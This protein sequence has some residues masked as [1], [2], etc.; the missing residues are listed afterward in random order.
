MDNRT[1]TDKKDRLLVVWTSSDR[2]VALRMLFMYTRNAKRMGWWDDVRLL[3]WGPSA[4]LLS[5]DEE[6]KAYIRDMKD[7][8]IE[9]IACKACSDGYGVSD[10]LSDLGVEVMYVGELFTEMLQDGW[11]TI[12][13]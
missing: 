2:E 10:A 8:G 9:L 6:L 11:T 1:D 13:F 3:I 5:E 12:T 7:I 4:K